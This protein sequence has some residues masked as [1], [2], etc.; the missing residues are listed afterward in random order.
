MSKEYS[1]IIPSIEGI[2]VQT[3]IDEL[4][5]YYCKRNIKFLKY[6]IKN[7]IKKINKLLFKTINKLRIR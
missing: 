1:S 6:N 7:A 4:E 5:E 2:I 3:F